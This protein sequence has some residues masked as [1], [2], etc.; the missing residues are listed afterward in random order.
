MTAPTTAAVETVDKRLDVRHD[1]N[2]AT[3][4]FSLWRSLCRMLLVILFDLKTY[5]V[6]N[7]PKT[8]GALI[9]AN[10]QSYLDPP[11]FGVNIRRPVSFL[12]KSGLFTNRWFGWAIRSV[13]AF[14]VRQ[15][16]GD[17]GAME[18]TIKR[19]KEGHLLNLYPEGGRSLDGE[20]APLQRGF[21]L[22]VKRSGVPI[23]P[24]VIDGS[25]N[26]WPI[27]RKLFRR[28][29]V[30]VLYGRP[31][32]TAGLKSDEIIALVDTTLRTMLA[33]LRAGRIQ[34]YL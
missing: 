9:V 20:I 19:L 13:H 23:V 30:R 27:H 32:K 18:E 1:P 11:A 17:K 15:G 12:A 33:D 31:L 22:V 16:R 6:K 14:P 2:H 4:W 25:F 24:A 29:P 28:H 10:H 26:A 21:A 5:G 7:V 3:A 34:Q 8:G